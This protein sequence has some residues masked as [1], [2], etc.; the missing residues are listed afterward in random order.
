[1]GTQW[2]PGTKLVLGTKM[3]SRD[4]S[5]ITMGPGNHNCFQEPQWVAGTAMG[6]QWV[7][8]T[9]MGPRNYNRNAMGPGD[10]NETLMGPKDHNEA[11]D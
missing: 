6:R 9:T 2:F 3:G 1:M 8:G 11:L 10:C 5:G 7:Q 4:R